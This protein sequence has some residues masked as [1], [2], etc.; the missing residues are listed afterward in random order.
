MAIWDAAALQPIIEEAGGCFT[1][2]GGEST[3]TGGSVIATNAVLAEAARGLLR[4]D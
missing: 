1:D 3:H 4:A 2:F